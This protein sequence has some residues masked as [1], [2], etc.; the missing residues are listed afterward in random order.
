MIEPLAVAVH[1]VRISGLKAGESVVVI[2]GG[3][4]GLFI[5]MLARKA[6]ASVLV[7]EIKPRDRKRR[8][9]GRIGA[10]APAIPGLVPVPRP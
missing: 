7:L 2:G 3:T 8:F 6:G 1:D 9:P 4:I 10:A 5:A